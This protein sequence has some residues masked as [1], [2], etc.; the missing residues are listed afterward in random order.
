M[1]THVAHPCVAL[2]TQ[3]E[4][5]VLRRNVPRAG[6]SRARSQLDGLKDMFGRGTAPL[7]PHPI[8]QT[9][10]VPSSFV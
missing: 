4:D 10:H 9:V 8:G 3:Y 2:F 6:I 5:Q 1:V 7:L